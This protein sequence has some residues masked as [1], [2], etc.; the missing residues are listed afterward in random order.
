[1]NDRFTSPHLAGPIAVWHR[2]VACVSSWFRRV[3]DRSP[4]R[5][6]LYHVLPQADYERLSVVSRDPSA[7]RATKQIAL[8]SREVVTSSRDWG[9]APD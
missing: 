1:M 6:Q 3:V 2:Q 9:R 5:R 4:N 8:Y 7:T